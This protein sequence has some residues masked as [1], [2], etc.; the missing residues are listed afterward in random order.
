MAYPVAFN[1][2]YSCDAA[3][4]IQLN[5]TDNKTYGL[6]IAPA[7]WEAFSD[8]GNRTE[9]QNPAECAFDHNDVMAERKC[10]MKKN[11]SRLI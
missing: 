4:E 1:S 7:N 6:K 11:I 2:S 8:F 3:A 5:V 10:P 9:L